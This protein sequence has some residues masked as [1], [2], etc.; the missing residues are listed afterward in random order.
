MKD[1]LISRREAL[2]AV[3]YITSSMS[4]CLNEDECHGMK[5]MQRQTILELTNMPS[6]QPP[7]E[8]PKR[9][10]WSGWQGCR[11][12]RY[13]CPLCK[14]LVRNDDVYCHRCGQHLMFP[15]I[16]FTPYIPGQ[17]QDVIVRWEDESE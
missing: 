12:T 15:N 11:D 7:K 16:S 4:I 3:E 5:R 8:I 9:V 17:K 13:R 2:D 1:D 6:A 10:L 14:K